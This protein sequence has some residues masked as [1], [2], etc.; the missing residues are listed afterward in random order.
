[1][2]DITRPTTLRPGD[3]IRVTDWLGSRLFRVVRE[4]REKPQWTYANPAA[5]DGTA[6]YVPVVRI[7]EAGGEPLAM[8]EETLLTAKSTVE[9]I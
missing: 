7:A 1:M 4:P 9:L 6:F 3:E 2:S 5:Y 8:A